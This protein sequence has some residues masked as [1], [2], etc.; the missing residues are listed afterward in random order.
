[1]KCIEDWFYIIINIQTL[2]TN[3]IINFFNNLDSHNSQ[4]LIRDIHNSLVSN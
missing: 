4:E 2:W 3:L 1:M